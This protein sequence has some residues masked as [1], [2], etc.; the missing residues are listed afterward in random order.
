VC[1]LN[2]QGGHGARFCMKNVRSQVF[3]GGR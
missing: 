3:R 1:V 2:Q